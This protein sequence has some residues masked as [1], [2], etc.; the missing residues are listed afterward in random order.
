MNFR[1][2]G[3]ACLLFSALLITATA[4][5]KNG[6]G[7]SEKNPS[8]PRSVVVDASPCD[9][10]TVHETIKVVGSLR[11]SERTVVTTEIAGKVETVHFKEGSVV[12]KRINGETS[13]A[14]VLV[15]L[16]DDLLQAERRNVKA[17]LEVSRADLKQARDDFRREKKLM[18]S[19]ATTEAKFTRAKIQLERAKASVQ[20]AEARLEEVE[21]RLSKTRIHAPFTGELGERKVSPG[22]YVQP[23]D[24]IV[25]IVRKD[26]IE[27]TFDVPE[28]FKSRLKT[29][30]TVRVQVA[31]YPERSYE[32][33]VFYVSPSA[34]PDT[35][36][37]TVKARIENPERELNPGMFASVRLIIATHENAP[38]IP[39]TAV[40]PRNDRHYVYAVKD[41]KAKRTEVRIGQRFPD[42][43]E[44]REGLDGTETVVVSG[45]QR[46]SEGVE[47]EIRNSKSETRNSKERKSK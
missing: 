1:T 35:R 30:Q 45:L 14:P 11:A 22:T 8:G 25:E 2:S 31:A 44:I 26:P 21:E 17:E 7:K 43:V 29:G 32:G 47:V 3:L 28:K 42:E 46:V 23:G 10:R 37:I 27:A 19:G 38:V 6:K 40:V 5:G 24:E 41:G 20:K 16:D 18:K 4:C 36:T 15:E 33:S 39:D 13:A 12:G 34:D 9:V